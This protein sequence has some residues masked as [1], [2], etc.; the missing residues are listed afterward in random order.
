MNQT[1][2]VRI[3]GGA[4]FPIIKI[5]N[6]ISEFFATPIIIN[7]ANEVLVDHFLREKIPFLGIQKIILNIMKDKNYKKYAI[8]KPNNFNTISKIDSWAKHITNEKIKYFYGK[9]N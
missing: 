4:T 6:R 9:N 1:P 2:A 3:E 5:L 7:S 8:R